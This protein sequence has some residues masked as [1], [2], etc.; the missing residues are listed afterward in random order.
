[1]TFIPTLAHKT[2]FLFKPNLDSGRR[3]RVYRQTPVWYSL[4]AKTLPV[5]ATFFSGLD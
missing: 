4:A 2:F 5:L 3:L 1:M